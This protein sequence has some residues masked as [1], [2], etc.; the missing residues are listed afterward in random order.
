MRNTA[1]TRPSQ[2]KC[3]RNT[4]NL[5][6]TQTSKSERARAA[7]QKAHLSIRRAMDQ[8]MQEKGVYTNVLV[9]PPCTQGVSGD[10]GV[11]EE[12]SQ[13]TQKPASCRDITLTGEPEFRAKGKTAI[14]SP[15][16]RIESLQGV[17]T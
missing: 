6:E 17:E 12:D 13:P 11:R 15:H 8:R 2:I 1:K 14:P 16:V 9:K 10:G 7:T 4:G 5:Y 3:E